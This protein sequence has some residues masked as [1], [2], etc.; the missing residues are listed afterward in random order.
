MKKLI[1]G[2]LLFISPL[3]SAV[4]CDDIKDMTLEQH[5]SLRFAYG[6]GSYENLGYTLAAIAWKESFAGKW[7][8]NYKTNDFGLY[9]VNIETAAKTLDIKNIYRKYE[10]AQ[11]LIFDDHLGSDLA[12]SVLK[13]FAS[14]GYRQML[15]SYN[16]GNKWL[17]DE[18]QKIVAEKY[19]NDI[20]NRVK[21]LQTCTS[22]KK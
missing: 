19:A 12:L 22:W 17:K 14:R 18:S 8:V 1:L 5:S 10:L 21:I 7:R 20:A 4:T 6:Q 16:R 11:K 2:A 3:V 15:M 13:H 9:H